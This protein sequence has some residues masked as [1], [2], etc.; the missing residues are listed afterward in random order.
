[1]SPERAG[2]PGLAVAAAMIGGAMAIVT[3]TG[4]SALARPA[5][6][7]ARLAE[8]ERKLDRI[9]I[10][11]RGAAVTVRPIRAARS[12]ARASA[13]AP[14]IVEQKLRAAFGQAKLAAIAFE[15][16]T[17]VG[18]SLLAV[19]FRFETVGSYE[20]AM[21]LLRGMDAA[22]PIA[23]RRLRRSGLQDFG[24]FP[25]VF[26]TF[27][28]LDLRAPLIPACAAV[29]LVL[30]ATAWLAAGRQDVLTPARTAWRP[31]SVSSL[32]HGLEGG[33]PSLIGAAAVC[34]V[35][36][37]QRR[38][39][40]GG[41]VLGVSRMPGRAA[42]LLAID[43]KPPAWLAR[44]ETR[45]GVVL[46]DV[47]S[48]RAALDLPLGVRTLRIGEATPLGP[49]RPPALGRRNPMFAPRARRHAAAR[50]QVAPAARQRAWLWRIT[51][52]S[53]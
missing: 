12:A 36:R 11:Q 20:D 2:G 37:P 48:G 30:G 44:G 52:V 29:G 50:L 46:R 17:P 3:A 1:M 16:S 14:G 25:P 6:R 5:D 7:A 35:H 47:G 18:D 51:C 28:L 32:K 39:R 9:E 34:S 53:K 24:R 19:N 15:P 8:V 43:G 33:A 23:L 4:L 40:S 41:G 31:S 26:R 49:R 21:T 38:A 27:L 13:A 42:A 45:D 22:R 10:L